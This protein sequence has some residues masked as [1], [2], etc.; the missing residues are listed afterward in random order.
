MSRLVAVQVDTAETLSGDPVPYDNPP[1][2][3]LGAVLGSVAA[4]GAV[5]YRAL[6]GEIKSPQ[7]AVGITKKSARRHHW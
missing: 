2:K 4:P 1:G 6:G 3:G 5:E 7:L